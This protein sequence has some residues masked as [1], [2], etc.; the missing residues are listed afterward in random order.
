MKL[1]WQKLAAKF[2]ALS[3]RERGMIGAAAVGGVLLIGFSVLVDPVSVS[4]RGL[5]QSIERQNLDLAGLRA[6]ITSL[7]AQL[8]SDPDAD[9]KAEIQELTQAI[10]ANSEQLEKMASGLVP[11]E[12]MNAVLE[13]ILKRN[14]GL[15]LVSFKTLAPAGLLGGKKDGK[16]E[17]P[18][19][20]ELFRHGVEIRLEGSYADLHAYL[21]QLEQGSQKL[22]WGEAR[23][24]VTEYPKAVLTLV[25][26]TVNS[27]KAWLAI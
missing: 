5:R 25:V 1:P 17:S 20:F 13:S 18:R 6:Q 4:N 23:L 22:L 27:D 2:D 16:E 9:R 19:D 10:R 14:P 8:R 26:Y 11:P 12:R 3:Q 7:E 24:A 15:R 21:A